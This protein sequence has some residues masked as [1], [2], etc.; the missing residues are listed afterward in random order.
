M[1]VKATAASTIGAVLETIDFTAYGAAAATVFPKLFFPSVDPN[2]AILAAFVTFG[3][4]FFARPLGG[5]LFGSLGDKLGRK[6][7]LIYTLALMGVS[8]FLM[9]CL[10]TYAMIGFGAP[11]LLTVLRFLQGLALGGESTGA[12]VLTVE[13][14]PDNRRGF[15]GSL[16]NIGASISAA[17][18]TG[19]FFVLSSTLNPEQFETWGWRVPFLL[20]FLLVPV[21]AYIRSKVSETPAFQE[22]HAQHKEERIPLFKVFQQYPGPIIRL[23]IIW[24]ATPALYNVINVFSLSYITKNLGLSGQTAF[25]ALMVANLTA[26]VMLVVCGALSDK[27][28]RKPVMVVAS[29]CMFA[30]ALAY[31]PMLHTKNWYIIFAA[32]TIA[33]CT[34]QAQNGVQPAFFAEPFPTRVRY[35]G[36]A[37]AYSGGVL[38]GGA[39][40]PFLLAYLIQKSSGD[41]WIISAFAA[42]VVGAAFIAI[43]FSPETRHLSLKR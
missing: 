12:Q 15:Y 31:F 35:S 3:V 32:M 25:L 14:A 34:I 11:L 22:T 42:V 20:S 30:I 27:V 17:L 26:T 7:V 39:P 2:I 41:V 40:T 36:S 9:G 37:I 18:A 24:C 28:G 10:P 4:G 19:M 8:T 29:I 13:H 6:K 21:G 38:I 33:A 43:L 5:M 23:L 16:I 1:A